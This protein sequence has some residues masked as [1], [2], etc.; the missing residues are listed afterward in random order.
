MNKIKLIA[1]LGSIV[2]TSYIAY[3]VWV[4]GHDIALQE[5]FPNIDP[6]LVNKIHRE[7]LRDTYAGK[8]DDVNTDEELDAEF[9]RR[10]QEY[11][12]SQV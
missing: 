11:Y 6:M 9:M 10:V 3:Q 8:L 12:S 2:G 5:R 7:M 1:V 4:V